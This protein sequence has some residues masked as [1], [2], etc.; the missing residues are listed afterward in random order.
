MNATRLAKIHR[1]IDGDSI[2]VETDHGLIVEVR[3]Y[4]ID[5]PEHGQPFA[6][7]A[8]TG[9]SRML[10]RKKFWLE[11]QHI[12]PY[13]RTAGLLHHQDRTRRNSVN[14]R[15]VREGYAYAYTKYGGEELG[16]HEAEADARQGRRGVWEDSRDGGERPWDYRRENRQEEELTPSGII[17]L[18]LI[19]L[20]L[21]FALMSLASNCN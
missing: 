20:I 6:D 2:E 13:G 5:A 16:F 11:E 21:L 15:M 10:G 14:L 1:I 19:G 8:R 3:L 9:L 4:G 18:M 7:E 12:D 17:G